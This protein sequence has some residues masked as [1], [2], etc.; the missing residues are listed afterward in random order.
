MIMG[1]DQKYLDMFRPKIHWGKIEIDE[2]KCIGC[3]QCV[4]NCPGKVPALNDD[5][6]AYMSRE[7]CITCSNCVVTCPTEAISIKET[8]YVEEGYYKT[9]PQ[10]IPYKSPAPPLDAD[11]LRQIQ[12][13][14]S[15]EI[16]DILGTD[17]SPEVVHRDNLV[18]L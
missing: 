5:E 4:D 11:D 15:R 10:D 8:F 17:S 1:L 13:R 7:E 9:I 16:A 12:G 14:R 3:G 18:L 6:K 2:E